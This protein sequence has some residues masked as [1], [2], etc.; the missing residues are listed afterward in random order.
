MVLK[1]NLE[2]I[3]RKEPSERT[4][5][6]LTF[7]AARLMDVELLAKLEAGTRLEVLR[8]LK[9]KLDGTDHEEKKKKQASPRSRRSRICLSLLTP[10][11]CWLLKAQSQ[12]RSLATSL[13]LRF[14]LPSP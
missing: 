9:A 12:E 2:S 6:E 1:L 14:S 13:S 11:H 8:R 5:V 4:P 7:A 3:L 10:S